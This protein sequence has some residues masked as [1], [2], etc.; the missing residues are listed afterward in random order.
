MSIPH[1]VVKA[2]AIK[3]G[4]LLWVWENAGVVVVEKIPL[5][6]MARSGAVVEAGG[7]GE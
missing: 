6:E 4:D 7:N 3:H 2:T 1:V 5:T